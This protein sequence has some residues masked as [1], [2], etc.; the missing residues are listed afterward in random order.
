MGPYPGFDMSYLRQ[1]GGC[2]NRGQWVSLK[3]SPKK[4]KEDMWTLAN[5]M[6]GEEKLKNKNKNLEMAKTNK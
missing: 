5:Q 1:S 2:E 4:E 3:T 6:K